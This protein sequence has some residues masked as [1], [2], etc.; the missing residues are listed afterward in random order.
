[1]RVSL[2]MLPFYYNIYIY[3]YLFQEPSK[4]KRKRGKVEV[5]DNFDKLVNKYKEQFIG[6]GN[7]SKWFDT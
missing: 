4:K 2:A 6:A 5:S 3:F 1:M 7:K